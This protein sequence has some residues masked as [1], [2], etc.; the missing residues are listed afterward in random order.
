MKGL[1]SFKCVKHTLHIWLKSSLFY[2][3]PYLSDMAT[4]TCDRTVT[5]R[6]FDYNSAL[7][8]IQ[9]EDYLED[10]DFDDIRFYRRH[11]NI[12]EGIENAKEKYVCSRFW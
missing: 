7:R 6:N 10:E 9:Q 2:S 4:Q 5:G 8:I 11:G 12:L 3:E 1:T